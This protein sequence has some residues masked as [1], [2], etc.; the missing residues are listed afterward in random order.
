[1]EKISC[2]LVVVRKILYI[3]TGGILNILI[4]GIT[5]FVGSH[6]ADY[7]LSLNKGHKVFGLT[8]WR[9][10]KDNIKHILDKIDLLDGDLLDPFSLIRVLTE[11]KPDIIFHLAAQSYVPTSY[12]APSNTLMI[13]GIGTINLLEAILMLSQIENYYGNH[14]PIISI[15]S[16]SEVYGQVE[17]DEVPIKETNQLR[18]ASP[19][20]VS[21]VTEDMLGR[22]YW[23]SHKLYT[24]ITRAF[25]HTGA[26]RGEVFF[27]SAF[28]KQIVKIEK[29]LQEPIIKV[30]NLNSVR[31]ICDVRDIVRAYWMLVNSEFKEYG[32]VFNIGG[33]ETFTVGDILNKLIAISYKEKEY[34][35]IKVDQD[36]LR[37]SD[38][39]L[40]IPDCT[41]FKK[42]TGWEPGI[43]VNDTL[44]SVLNYWRQKL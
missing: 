38:V 22:Q 32:Q 42:V 9:S 11:S 29:G 17:K 12:N 30:G 18:P 4:T 24:L 10:S 3:K 41:K 2:F 44:E 40:Q 16:S 25:T 36:L 14:Y 31:T 23:D 15:C 21:K 20:A 19:Y 27:V 28:A 6:L 5:G 39:T 8:R 13:N 1:V 34:F 26:R 43:E 35:K 37:L 33:V 7:I